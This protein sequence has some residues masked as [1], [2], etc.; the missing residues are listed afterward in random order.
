MTKR[1][2]GSGF[3]KKRRALQLRR[4]PLCRM[5]LDNKGLVR[6]ATV[7]HHVEQHQNDPNIFI[8]S[9]LMSLCSHH[10]DSQMQQIERLGYDPTIGLDGWPLDPRHPANQPRP[11]SKPKAA[12]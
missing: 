1:L 8:C 12:K 6:R 9:P 2:L 4:E 5:C 3:W 7:A 11:A 10:H